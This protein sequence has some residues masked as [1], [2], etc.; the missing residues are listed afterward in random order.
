[1]KKLNLLFSIVKTI[2]KQTSLQYVAKI[3]LNRI[4]KN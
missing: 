1:M 2:N 4:F 3:E